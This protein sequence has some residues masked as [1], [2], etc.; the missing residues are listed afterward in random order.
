M[1]QPPTSSKNTGHTANKGGDRGRIRKIPVLG[2][3]WVA[4]SSLFSHACFA[5][6]ES[7]HIRIFAKSVT[8]CC[9]TCLHTHSHSTTN[10][11][12]L[13]TRFTHH[14][15]TFNQPNKPPHTNTKM[16]FSI[17]LVA[18]AL[19]ATVT[20]TAAYPATNGT[21][22]AAFYPTG[23]GSASKPTGTGHSSGKPSPTSQLPFTGAASKASVGGAMMVVVGGVALVN[24]T[25]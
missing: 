2:V 3:G 20:A 12:N 13:H 14:Q 15:P 6:K 8:Y 9:F 5:R 11:T 1:S 19:A 7:V 16:Q 24:L 23:T 22:S 21:V 4:S 18:A 10:Q 17:T 25:S